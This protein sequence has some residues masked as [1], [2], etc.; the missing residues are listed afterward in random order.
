MLSSLGKMRRRLSHFALRDERGTQFVE[1]A[2][3]LPVMLLFFGAVAEFGRYFYTYSTLAKAA[4]AGARYSISRPYDSTNINQAK[5]LVVYGDQS[6]GCSGTPVLP[7]LACANVDIKKTTTAG[8][9]EVVTASIVNYPYQP[10]LDLGKLTGIT[11]A[12]L[13][14]NVGASVTMKYIY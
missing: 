1:L 10:I 4:R 9:V 2:L 13:S 14:G 8:G 3:V 6:A 7:G 12:S 11:A 5:S